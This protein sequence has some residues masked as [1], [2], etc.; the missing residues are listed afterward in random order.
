MPHEDLLESL[1]QDARV[2]A[3]SLTG[4]GHADAAAAAD[5]ALD[6]VYSVFRGAWDREGRCEATAP[7][8][9][10][11]LSEK[12][13]AAAVLAGDHD[14]LDEYKRHAEQGDAGA[15]RRVAELLEVVDEVA[16]AEQWWRLAADLGDPDAIDYVDDFVSNG[17]SV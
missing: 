1:R 15:A 14:V 2:L 16:K 12:E 3:R 6:Q 10:W 5:E 4:L 9:G 7:V 17:S 13:E 8:P 11:G